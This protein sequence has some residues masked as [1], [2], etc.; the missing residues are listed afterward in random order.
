MPAM[1]GY[2]NHT[3]WAAAAPPKN[4]ACIRRTVRSLSP[5]EI[6]AVQVYK[7][8]SRDD[9]HRSGTGLTCSH[10]RLPRAHQAGFSRRSLV[11][12]GFFESV[13]CH[14]PGLALLTNGGMQQQ[15]LLLKV[16]SQAIP[17]IVG[18]DTH[19][20]T[21]AVGVVCRCKTKAG[22]RRSQ[23]GL[24]TRTRLS[25]LLKLNL[26]TVL[27]MTWFHYAA[28]QFPCARHH[29]KRKRRWVGVK[30]STRN[31]HRDPKWPSARRLHMVRKNPGAPSEGATCTW[32]AADEAVGCMCAFIT[33]WWSSGQLV[34]RGCPEPGLPV[35]G[36]YRIHWSQHLLT[37]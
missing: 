24:H 31:G 7:A 37:T 23:Q 17:C 22:L 19:T 14:G 18:N 10:P 3:H 5:E 28:I 25:S 15:H 16:N 27:K 33:M 30:G 1:V 9:Y 29:S 21:S 11:G 34:Y 32:M 20:I 36:F 13:R 35:N 12:V 4:E 2:L 6:D 26:D 8:G